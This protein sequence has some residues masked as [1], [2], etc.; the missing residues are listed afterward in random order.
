MFVTNIVDIKRK[1]LNQIKKL[2][3]KITAFVCMTSFDSYG[4]LSE[5][6]L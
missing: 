2:W 6:F 3:S 5:N 1:Y 4:S